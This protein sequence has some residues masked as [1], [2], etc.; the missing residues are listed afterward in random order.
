MSNWKVSEKGEPSAKWE[1]SVIDFDAPDAE[2]MARSYAWQGPHKII[3][4]SCAGS[5]EY[6]APEL[7]A[8]QLRFTAASYADTLNEA[9]KRSGHSEAEALDMY[10]LKMKMC[11]ALDLNVYRNDNWTPVSLSV[12]PDT[13]QE[14]WDKVREDGPEALAEIDMAELLMCV[15]AELDTSIS[16]QELYAV[17]QDPEYADVEN[18]L[19]WVVSKQWVGE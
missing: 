9:A 19:R 11:E 13:L 1:L 5:A 12:T 17:M 15:G 6:V 4:W 3:V 16:E 18:L 8:Q 7:L 10:A 14:F 2:Q